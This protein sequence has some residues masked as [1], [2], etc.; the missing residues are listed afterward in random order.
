MAQG[1]L[2]CFAEKGLRIGRAR[3]ARL[4]LKSTEAYVNLPKL[5]ESAILT[6]P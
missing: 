2:P 5:T 6:W 4:W 3:L 1:E